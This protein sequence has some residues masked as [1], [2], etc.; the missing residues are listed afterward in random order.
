[1]LRHAAAWLQGR[2]EALL[3]GPTRA[4]A[5]EC[6]RAACTKGLLG[7]HRATLAQLAAELAAPATAE[8][9]LAQASRLGMEAVAARVTDRLRREGKLAYFGPVADA[10]GF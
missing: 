9:G 1:M 8:R 6:A 5:D 3:I 10:P 4:A 2:D 7:V